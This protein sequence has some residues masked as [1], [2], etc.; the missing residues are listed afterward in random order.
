[1]EQ[2]K[3]SIIVP[4][5]N[6][7]R[8]LD[9][10]IESIVNQ[11][12][13]NL[14]V[15]LIDDGATDNSGKICDKWKKKDNRILVIHKKNGGVSKARNEGIKIATG[16]YIG[17][18][19]SDDYIEEDM[20]EFL[21]NNLNDKNA[22]ISICSV[23]DV[24]EKNIKHNKLENIDIVMNNV[25][26]LTNIFK[27][28]Y[29]GNGMHNKLFKSNLIKNNYFPEDIK[30]GEELIVLFRAFKNSDRIVYESIPKYYYVN[31]PGSAIHGFINDDVC[32]NK[33]G[34]IQENEQFLDNYSDLKNI[35]YNSYYLS[36]FQLY[37]HCILYNGSKKNIRY[38]KEELLKNKKNIMF[39]E[40]SKQKK[41]QL[42]LFYFNQFTYK[43]LLKIYGGIKKRL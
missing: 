39:K 29:Y 33:L 1:M 18:I 21:V 30:N 23:Y 25:T 22:D 11:T 28:G 2:K 34:L 6:V 31:R 36:L 42:K 16:D 13:D 43:I 41:I 24:N 7:E 32:R 38:A 35:V 27:N 3:I 10:C 9:R 4:I 8:Y 20:Y 12:Y 40:L 17:F 26:G 14:E 5:Y 19:D 15:I 37:N